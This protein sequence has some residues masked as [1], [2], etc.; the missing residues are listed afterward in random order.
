MKKYIFWTF[1]A[2][3]ACSPDS[4][5]SENLLV[6]PQTIEV[7]TIPV[8]KGE[9]IQ[10]MELPGLLY[11][12]NEARLSFKTGGVISKIYV[13][14]GQ[15]IREG[16]L[17]ASLKSEEIDAQVNQAQL[18]KE[19]A[20]RDF[21]RASALLQDSAITLEQ[22][23]NAK[24]GLSAAEEVLNQ[25]KFNLNFS[26][27]RAPFSGI[28][29]KKIGNEGEITGPGAPI[30]MVTKSGG[31]NSYVLR[32]G[33]TDLQ[34]SSIETGDQASIAMDAY[35]T[36]IFKGKVFQKLP[37]AD[38]ISGLLQIEISVDFEQFQP[39]L[40]MYGKAILN[41]KAK[42]TPAKIP[43]DA[44][45]DANGKKGFVFVPTSQN[46]AQKIEVEILEIDQEGAWIGKGLENDSLIILPRSP[47]LKE[48]SKISI[49]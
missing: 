23:Q 22:F 46:T 49:R 20:Q 9:L 31:K 5:P 39:V 48:N 42:I 18:A 10:K 40:G 24:T 7:T 8:E 14:E 19:K 21:D 25:V 38:P 2:A 29:L 17:L 37:A 13:D 34:W 15:K 28:V 12:Q 16:Q 4:N 35:P 26:S 36:K 45:L 47:F 44:L 1:L 32:T 41:S 6:E 33:V 11:A 43:L 30:L 3:S 27:I